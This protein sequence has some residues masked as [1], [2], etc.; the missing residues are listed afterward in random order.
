LEAPSAPGNQH[1]TTAP[2]AAHPVLRD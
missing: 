2:S 1:V